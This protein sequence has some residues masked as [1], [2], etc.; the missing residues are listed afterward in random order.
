MAV[1]TYRLKILSL[2][3]CREPNC[4]TQCRVTNPTAAVCRLLWGRRIQ[5][6]WALFVRPEHPGPASD[7]TGGGAARRHPPRP[8]TVCAATDNRLKCHNQSHVAQQFLHFPTKMAAKDADFTAK[9]LW[10]PSYWTEAGK[11]VLAVETPDYICVVWNGIFSVLG[12]DRTKYLGE[13]FFEL[14]SL[15]GQLT[16][17]ST[18]LQ[19]I[20]KKW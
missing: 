4:V 16:V 5:K 12:T 3:Q 10:Q 7:E 19:M 6:H 18:I 17:F 15:K 14:W 2:P 11:A 8:R 9:L 13:L 20:L 1:P